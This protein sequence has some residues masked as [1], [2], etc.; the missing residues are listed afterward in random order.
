MYHGGN[1]LSLL[2]LN[3]ACINAEKSIPGI[4]PII[5]PGSRFAMSTIYFGFVGSLCCWN[6]TIINGTIAHKVAIASAKA[7]NA[8]ILALISITLSSNQYLPRSN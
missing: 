6:N 5:N 4:C 8:I 7:K 3:I 1:Q 2:K